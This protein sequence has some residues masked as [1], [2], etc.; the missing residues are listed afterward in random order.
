L[1]REGF[2]RCILRVWRSS[3]YAPTAWLDGA[4]DSGGSTCPKISRIWALTLST[5]EIR[6]VPFALRLHTPIALPLHTPFALRL[7]TPFALRLYTP[8]ALTPS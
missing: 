3:W 4:A 6:R 1:Q 7:H 5:D 8:F 2:R